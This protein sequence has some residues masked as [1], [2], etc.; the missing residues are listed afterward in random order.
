MVMQ[1]DD[2]L[3]RVGEMAAPFR[4][5]LGEGLM[6]A[7]VG[8]RQMID[9]GQQRA[10]ELAV[11]GHAADRDAAEADAVVAALAADQP[12][13]RAVS[14]HVV[15]GEG[16]LQRGVARLRAGVGEEHVIE[17]GGRQ[18]GDPRG[19]LEH[20]RMA[21]VEGRAEIELARLT[22]DRLDDPAAVVAGVAA[23]QSRGRIKDLAAFRRIVVHVLRTRDQS[24]PLLEGAVRGE[25]HPE[26]GEVIG[27]FGAL[28]VGGHA[29]LLGRLE[30]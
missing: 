13:A 25:R 27:D 16:D 28:S 22:L 5:A 7:V 3:E 26:C 10:E 2:V 21:K 14:A 17:I 4:L 18:R 20:Q 6:L 19:E 24:R 15:I 29:N 8:R 9:S 23:P 1:R 12:L 11:V 30:F